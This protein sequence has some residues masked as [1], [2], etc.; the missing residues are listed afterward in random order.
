[1]AYSINPNLPKARA[2]AMKLLILEQL[3]VQVV[4]NKCGVHRSTIY[5]WKHKW[6]NLNKNVQLTNDNRPNRKQPKPSSL[7]RLAAC[8]NCGELLRYL[9][10]AKHAPKQLKAS[11]IIQADS[12]AELL[13]LNIR[14]MLELKLT[15]ETNLLKLQ[16]KLTEAR[17]QL[18]GWRK[19]I[20]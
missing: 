14:A 10:L 17:R 8:K 12:H 16:A 3:P 9:I 7:F 5:R 11:Y 6:D 2:L 19:S 15:N 20:S 1:M 4:A 18:G 13:A